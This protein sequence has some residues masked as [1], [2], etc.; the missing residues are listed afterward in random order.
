MLGTHF[1]NKT[2]RKFVTI[3]G[4]LFNNITLI[5]T[6][7]N[8][9]IERILVPITYSPKEKFLVRIN[10]DPTLSKSVQ[11]T[12]PIMS[13]ERTSMT[14]DSSRQIIRNLKNPRITSNTTADS[15]Y[16]GVPYDITFDLNIFTR[17]I[18]DADQILEQILPTFTPDYNV[19]ANLIPELG[20]IKDIP[21]ILNNVSEA[22]DYEGSLDTYRNV[23]YTLSFTMKAWFFGPVTERKIIR[24]VIA[25]TFID[26][27]IKAGYISTMNLGSGNGSFKLEDIAYQ[28]TNPNLATASGIVIK[29]QS[30]NS[31]LQLGGIQGQF[32]TNSKIHGLST[33]ASYNL[34]SFSATPHKL[35]SIITEPNPLTANGSSDYGYTQTITEYP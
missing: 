25:N 12:L 22:I 14:Y 16:V 5:R 8:T 20:F 34:S 33:N 4:N 15:Q 30:A 32:V 6:T 11:I 13:F 7:G 1:Y 23:V 3:F 9:E 27:S 18:D 17:N 28:G 21:I 10:Q 26:P 35:F 31:I 2:S 29:Y 24:K 19:S